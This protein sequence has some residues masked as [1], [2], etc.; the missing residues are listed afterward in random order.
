MARPRA[1]KFEVES[2]EGK[3][4]LSTMHVANHLLPTMHVANHPKT[5][6]PLV[7]T[8]SLKELDV[9]KFSGRLASMGEVHATL[10]DVYLF[11]SDP[12]TDGKIVLA[13]SKGSVTLG[14]DQSHIISLSNTLAKSVARVPFHVQS[15]TGAYAGASGTGVFTETLTSEADGWINSYAMKLQTIRSH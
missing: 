3:H 7:L 10:F 4:L 13:N 1:R 2:L 15:G 8:G 5:P 12:H 6:A 14:L 11:D 9:D